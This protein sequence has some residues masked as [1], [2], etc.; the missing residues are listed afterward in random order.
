[1]F[2]TKGL[3]FIGRFGYDTYNQNSITRFKHPELWDVNRYRNNGELVFTRVREQ[4]QM[5]QASSSNGEK[6]EFFESELH[7]NRTFSDHNFGGVARYT[8]NSRVFTQNIGTDLKNGI[9]RRNQGIAGR[10]FYN[11]KS[12]Y[13]VD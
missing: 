1:D 10:V 13:F 7:Y 4:L 2:I 5:V 11:W 9:A 6:R 8:Q 12:R 3:W